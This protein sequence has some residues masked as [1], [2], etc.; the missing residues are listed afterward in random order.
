MAPSSEKRVFLG[1][2]F[3]VSNNYNSWSH[4]SD[5]VKNVVLNIKY[6]Y[7]ALATILCAG[8]SFI[9]CI[10]YS[11]LFHFDEV[12]STHCN[13]YNVAPSISS[14]IGGAAP[15]RYVWTMVMALHTGPKLLLARMNHSVYT[16]DAAPR[17]HMLRLARLTSTLSL[18]E[19]T[20][21]LTVTLVPS[22]E[23]YDLHI[24]ATGVFLVCSSLHMTLSC[25]LIRLNSNSS[26]FKMGQNHYLQR[27]SLHYKQVL[28]MT[29]LSSIAISMYF[30]WRHNVYCEPGIYSV[31]SLCE[32]IVILSNMAYHA[33]SYYD[34]Y[35]VNINLSS[36]V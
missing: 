5:C 34:F 21:L 1:Q 6:R 20:S 4:E 13:V 23:L 15:Q 27:K 36:L 16:S 25:Y 33:T 12:T 26:L 24:L 11:F 9:F 19:L 3:P 30:F 32:Y 7:L 17:T 22:Y 8:A 18:A 31:F 35:H 10:V 2:D 14:S 28:L 29:H